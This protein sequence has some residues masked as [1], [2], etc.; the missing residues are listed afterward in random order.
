MC[1]ICAI[2]EQALGEETFRVFSAVQQQETISRYVD[3]DAKQAISHAG[4]E[5][6]WLRIKTA[7]GHYFK[8]YHFPASSAKGPHTMCLDRRP[9]C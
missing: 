5:R 8:C 1:E 3:W 6:N 2:R 4:N 7:G 9:V